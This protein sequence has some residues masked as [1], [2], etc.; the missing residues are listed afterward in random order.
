M[1]KEADKV[2]TVMIFDTDTLDKIYE[3]DA[4]MI[5]EGIEKKF[6]FIEDSHYNTA[7]ESFSY[8]ASIP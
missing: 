5:D 3:V 2:T 7:G 8:D 4:T 1:L 6:K